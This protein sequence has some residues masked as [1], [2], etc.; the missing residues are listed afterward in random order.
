VKIRFGLAAFAA[1]ALALAC[2]AGGGPG[3][4]SGGDVTVIRFR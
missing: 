4:M 2:G 1:L 3:N